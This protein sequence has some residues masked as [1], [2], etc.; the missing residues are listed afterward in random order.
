VKQAIT[1]QQQH[2]DL[3]AGLKF[4]NVRNI[5]PPRLTMAEAAFSKALL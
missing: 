3:A 5:P 4:S 1:G 2:T